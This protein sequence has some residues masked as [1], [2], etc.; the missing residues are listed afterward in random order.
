MLY[1]RGMGPPARLLVASRQ[2]LGANSTLTSLD[3]SSN[4]LGGDGTVRAEPTADRQ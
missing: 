3:I 2:G 1:R 4:S